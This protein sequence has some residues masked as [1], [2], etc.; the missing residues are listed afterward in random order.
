[1]TDFFKN[2]IYFD[3]FLTIFSFQF[4]SISKEGKT[5]SLALQ[6][7]LLYKFIYWDVAHIT[8]FLQHFPIAPIFRCLCSFYV[9]LDDSFMI[10]KDGFIC[11]IHHLTA[12]PAC[13][14]FIH[15]FIKF[16]GM[17]FF[18]LLRHTLWSLLSIVSCFAGKINFRRL[19][20]C[21][22]PTALYRFI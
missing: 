12:L 1:M 13:Q 5:T 2:C 22:L 18:G 15:A 10:C 6:I 19:N 4:P 7:Q 17:F 11:E 14:S 20:Y 3:S 16:Y 21:H 9:G 8:Y